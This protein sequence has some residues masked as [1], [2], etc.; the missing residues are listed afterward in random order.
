MTS[1]ALL[2]A[3]GVDRLFFDLRHRL[4]PDDPTPLFHQLANA[5]RWEIGM[6]RLS[7]DTTL[8]T[9]HELAD[10]VGVHY[11]TARRAYHQLAVDGV[12]VSRRGSGTRLVASARAEAPIGPSRVPEVVECN[13][14]EAAQLARQVRR[15]FGIATVARV[16][17]GLPGTATAPVLTTT[18]HAAEVADRLGGTSS[19]VH[20]LPVV[21]DPSSVDAVVE[22]MRRLNL[23]R[24][25][26]VERDVGTG[27]GLAKEIGKQV[28][29]RFVASVAD[30]EWFHAAAPADDHLVLLSPRVWDAEPDS[31][32][33]LPNVM[34]V[35]FVFDEIALDAVARHHGWHPVERVGQQEAQ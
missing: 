18:F 9:I 20:A 35:R 1:T 19:L 4:R 32:H 11:H 33:D 5:L 6:G 10:A 30:P 34:T 7:V 14:T 27:D 28:G 22:R 15:R 21:L 16:I 25:V 2:D 29:N 26:V 13:L 12:L 24:L 3:E 23:H 17:D 31:L 8:P